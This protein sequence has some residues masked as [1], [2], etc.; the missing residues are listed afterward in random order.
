MLSVLFLTACDSN[1]LGG[2]KSQLDDNFEPGKRVES[3]APPIISSIPNFSMDE[4][5]I[6]S[7][8]FQIADPDSFLMCSSI[9]IKVKSSNEAL[10]A[11]TDMVVGGAF[12]NC[13]L[14]FSPKQFQFGVSQITVEL[15]DFWTIVTAS[16]TLTVNHVVTPGPFAIVDAEGQDRAVALT[17]NTP[18]YM[19]GSSARY[20]VFFRETGSTG[21]YSQ[22][23]P[24]ASP[25][26]VSGLVNGQSYDFY[27]RANNSIGFRDTNVVEAT[28]TKY[29][30]RGVEFV[31]GSQQ[32]I[33]SPASTSGLHPAG[34]VTNATL[35]SGIDTGDGN[36]PSNG[37]GQLNYAPSE[38]PA[39]SYLPATPVSYLT[40]PSGNY[41]VYMNS[42]QNILSG[43]EQ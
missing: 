40:T 28:P 27:V 26:T 24:A 33:S 32:Y 39:N 12:P 18:T 5:D 35:V 14:R 16:L 1:L 31:V 38:N 30:L 13:T 4:N 9:Y 23:T 20:T 2:S 29:K 7:V 17:W 25:Y 36:F 8:S 34:F 22:I 19:T 3:N 41:K 6:R 15:Y 42:Q 10:I 21:G 11:P 37:S 43:A